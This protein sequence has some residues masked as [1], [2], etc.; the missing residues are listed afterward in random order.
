MLTWNHGLK[1]HTSL[2]PTVTSIIVQNV[3][4][5]VAAAS[6]RRIYRARLI[7]KLRVILIKPVHATTE[8]VLR[9]SSVYTAKRSRRPET[10]VE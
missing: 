1:A 7:R 4:F 5:A 8:L 2:G 10:S 6:C 9:I 3:N